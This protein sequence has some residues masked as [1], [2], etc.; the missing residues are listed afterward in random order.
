[1]W[2]AAPYMWRHMASFIYFDHPCS[3]MFGY[4]WILEGEYLNAFS[5]IRNG[6]DLSCVKFWRQCCIQEALYKLLNPDHN[7]EYSD[8]HHWQ[9]LRKPT[10]FKQVHTC[11]NRTYQFVTFTFDERNMYLSCVKIAVLNSKN[12]ILALN[13]DHNFN[14]SDSHCQWQ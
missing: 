10:N 3:W 1:M 9:G 11:R 14:H 4:L 2:S 12:F 8:F 7:F 6:P 13:Q 5:P